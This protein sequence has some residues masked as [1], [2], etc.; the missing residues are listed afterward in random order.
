MKDERDREQKSVGR[1]KDGKILIMY[2]EDG[3]IKKLEE[4]KI[5]EDKK[6]KKERK[7]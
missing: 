7:K 3:G 4:M 2:I 5:K 6:S 1:E